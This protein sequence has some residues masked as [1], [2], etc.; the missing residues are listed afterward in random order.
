MVVDTDEMEPP[1]LKCNEH[2]IFGGKVGWHRKP[3]V[4]T[5][6]ISMGGLKDVFLFDRCNIVILISM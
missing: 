5:I 3:Q 1:L 2:M 6:A 4:F